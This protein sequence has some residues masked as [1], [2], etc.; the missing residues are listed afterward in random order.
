MSRRTRFEIGKG[1]VVRGQHETPVDP[2]MEPVEL[3][4][5][6]R[7]R[8]DALLDRLVM[9]IGNG[10]ADELAEALRAELQPHQD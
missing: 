6:Q 8:I 7:E 10:S 3:S 4:S 5:E 1:F 9:Q 2:F